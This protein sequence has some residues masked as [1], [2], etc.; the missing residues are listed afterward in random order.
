MEYSPPVRRFQDRVKDLRKIQPTIDGRFHMLDPKIRIV[1]LLGRLLFWGIFF[2]FA[3]FLGLVG[4]F[5]AKAIN[6]W[7]LVG[8]GVLGLLGLLHISWSF[9]GY[10]YWGYCVR[11]TDFLLRRGVWWRHI[12]A[13]PFA[14]IQHV[15]TDSGPLERSFGLANLVV[16]TAGAHEGSLKVPGLPE[17]EAERLRDLLSKVGHTHANL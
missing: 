10:R 1:W 12:S 3:F 5:S 11:D 16:H 7:L 14:R 9:I 17:D 2:V 15:D 13:I 6:L 8:V 4:L